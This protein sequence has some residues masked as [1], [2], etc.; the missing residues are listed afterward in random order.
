MGTRRWEPGGGKPGTAAGP[1][2]YTLSVFRF[3][4]ANLRSRPARTLLA[5]VGLSVAIAG[6]VGLFSIAGGIEK[7]VG[8]TFNKIPG[9]A[10]LQRGSPMPLFSV[11]P[12]D[13]ESEIATVEGVAV[14]NAEVWGRANIINGRKIVSPPRLLLG[15]DLS[16]RVQLTVEPL[17]TGLVEGR[18][19]E[20]GDRGRCY[21]AQ[22]IAEQFDAGPGDTLKINGQE[23]EVVGI[24]STGS[25]FID[26]TIMTDEQT[27]RQM[28]RFDGTTVS[29]FYAEVADGYDEKVVKKAIESRFAGRTLQRTLRSPGLLSDGWVGYL[30]LLLAWLTMP[31]EEPV[32]GDGDE[33]SP[34]EVSD[35][36]DW[37]KRADSFTGDLDLFLFMLSAVGVLIAVLSVLNTML[38]SVAE[39]TTEFGVLRA[40]G[41]SRGQIVRLIAIE[42]AAIGSLGGLIG[43]TVGWL[44]TQGVNATLAD[45]VHL[46][47]SPTL[48]A[49]AV[50][51]SGLLGLVGGMYPAWRAAKL[52]PI[53]AI[54]RTA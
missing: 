11:L 36:D 39:R 4:L 42:S 23:L 35:S 1:A 6:M 26:V 10:V 37:A 15:T 24:Y 51:L 32:A 30:E 33:V 50:F 16:S 18:F 34:I 43:A 13:W 31:E 27:M 7:V 12:A 22:P 5:T 49:N 3:A 41:W 8:E 54:R 38:M 25:P 52:S 40:N 28:S 45:K 44:A 46:Y 9:L 47:A 14:V 48:L 53:D 21:I 17:R 29:D 2:A 20:P 19:L